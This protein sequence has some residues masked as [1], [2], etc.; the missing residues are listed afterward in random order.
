[1]FATWVSATESL[2]DAAAA[3]RGTR[4][5]RRLMIGPGRRR[6]HED[7]RALAYGGLCLV[8]I[9]VGWMSVVLLAPA[10][11]AGA[12]SASAPASAPSS[13]Q[14][15]DPTSSAVAGQP[16]D[17][18]LAVPSITPVPSPTKTAFYMDIY[19]P[20]TFVS[21]A[22][23]D[24]CMAGAIQ[25]MV[26]IIGPGSDQTTIRQQQIANLAGSLT[27]RD[28]SHNGGFGPGGWALTM[29]Q[30]GAGQYKLVIDSTFDQAMRDAALALARTTR[31]VG[32]L[33]W[34]GA[35][36][37]VMT[38]FRADADPLL[39]PDTFK[40]KGAFIVD[41]F[42]PGS[43]ASGVRRWG[44][45]PSG[46]W[47]RWPTTTWLEATGGPLPRPR[48]EVAARRPGR[49]E[50][51]PPDR[52]GR[53]P[54]RVASPGLPSDQS[55]QPWHRPEIVT[56]DRSTAKPRSAA[57]AS[58]MTAPVSGLISHVAPHPTQWRWPWISCGQDVVLLAAVR[59]VAVRDQA[60]FLE[61]IERPVD[62]RWSGRGVALPAAGDQLGG[63]DVPLVL[64]QDL[65]QGSALRRPAQPAGAQAAGDAVPG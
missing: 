45:T 12:P 62:R 25:N 41:P 34:W 57:S 28:D 3:M 30:L 14:I 4:R 15:T 61:E 33:T 6:A 59:A 7:L 44:R 2:S 21:Q 17:S 56:C 29:P 11:A 38:G 20:G 13:A 65:D 8:M 47:P 48:R 43:A 63:R 51:L 39:F 37:W 16:A 46:T 35:H 54:D 22:N 9:C 52:A 55:W 18:P 42:Y 5:N 36:S 58:T 50:A 27:T 23:R 64:A 26:N 31:P 10:A 40:L 49:F 1:M 24:Y 60:E 32:L 19:R 53:A